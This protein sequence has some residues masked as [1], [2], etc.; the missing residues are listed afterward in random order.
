MFSSSGRTCPRQA[1]PHK[2]GRGNNECNK[3]IE[4]QHVGCRNKRW[5]E[6]E[7]RVSVASWQTGNYKVIQGIE[8]FKRTVSILVAT[9]IQRRF[10]RWVE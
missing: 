10:C 1:R 4:E 9:G 7:R 8:I 5:R 2:H 6:A 3:T